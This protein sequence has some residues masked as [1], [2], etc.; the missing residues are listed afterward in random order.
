MEV[1][2]GVALGR[3]YIFAAYVD[4]GTVQAVNCEGAG[5]FVPNAVSFDSSD[6]LVGVKA[7]EQTTK[8]PRC[9][10]TN[11]HELLGK[12]Q[13]EI[14]LMPEAK[15]W[16][17]KKQKDELI[18]DVI[19]NGKTV[20]RDLLFMQKRVF[21]YLRTQ[22][23]LQ[24][25]KS[26]TEMYLARPSYFST[27][28]IRQIRD[29]AKMAGFSKVGICPLSLAVARAHWKIYH[30]GEHRKY[31]SC[32]VREVSLEDIYESNVHIDKNMFTE[33]NQKR[34]CQLSDPRE[35]VNDFD[36]WM[37][38]AFQVPDEECCR[39]RLALHEGVESFRLSNGEELTVERISKVFVEQSRR[40]FSEDLPRDTVLLV[41]GLLENEK[42]DPFAHISEGK[43]QFHEYW[44]PAWGAA[45]LG[46][47]ERR[48][49]LQVKEQ[50]D[51]IKR[52]I[53]DRIN[54]QQGQSSNEEGPSEGIEPETN[55]H[56]VPEPPNNRDDGTDRISQGGK[57]NVISLCSNWTCHLSPECD[58]ADFLQKL[59]CC[60]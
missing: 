15:Y 22:A 10:F 7:I 25:R 20:Q 54:S 4:N 43:Y 5:A 9:T 47:D 24:S 31:S 58:A 12:T 44:A 1:T 3:N 17:F 41:G 49:A 38:A 57:R 32:I 28:Q 14:R 48:S 18:F 56:K 60:C 40:L 27:S 34:M 36:K 59:L 26:I 11:I 30:G 50:K 21:Q 29:A 55:S 2:L 51:I 16:K 39:A 23:Q 33:V 13:D 6:I 52:V 8:N 37:A 45:V 53:I 42:C 35:S 46:D 19:V